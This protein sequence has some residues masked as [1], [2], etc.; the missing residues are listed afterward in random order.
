MSLAG[1]VA[2]VTGGSQGI[3]KAIS[4]ALA[5]DGATVIVNYSRSQGPADATVEEIHKLTG[6]STCAVAIKANVSVVPEA[7]ALVEQ[8]VKQ[9]GKI[10]ILIC[11]A[12]K[13]YGEVDLAGTTEALYDEA[14]NLNVKG[15]Y[16]MVQ[17]AA[18]HIP[19][20]GRIILFS[21]S[22]TINSQIPPSY[23]LYAATK[24]AI[25]QMTRVLAKDLGKRGI[26]VNTV[27]PGPTA[28]D[29]FFEGKTE[30]VVSFIEKWAP[31]AR[32]GKPEEISGTVKFLC[33]E[34]AAWVNGQNIAVN[35]GA[36][37]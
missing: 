19:Y 26:T 3:G 22:L 9:F 1:K 15:V 33:T 36:M 28:T 11:N 37:V 21:S 35:G 10:D 24:G 12:G 31:S 2:L 32:L 6:S 27:S 14:F 7:K 17:E 23:L 18:P 34:E 20:G 5:K 4:L 13:I 30:Q 29:G 25:E 16:F 8:V